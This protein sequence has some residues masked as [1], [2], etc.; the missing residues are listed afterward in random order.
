MQETETKSEGVETAELVA[1]ERTGKDEKDKIKILVED[2]DRNEY[3]QMLSLYE[4]T[5][6]VIKENQKLFQV[7]EVRCGSDELDGAV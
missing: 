1:T 2:Y 7:C 6:N 4:R 5:F 3:E